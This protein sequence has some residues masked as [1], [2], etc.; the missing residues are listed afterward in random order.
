MDDELGRAGDTEEGLLRSCAE[1]QGCTAPGRS[2]DVGRGDS[3]L[4]AVLLELLVLTLENTEVKHQINAVE[5]D[6]SF[7]CFF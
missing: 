6:S 4:V 3:L 7:K 2:T 5:I 1:T